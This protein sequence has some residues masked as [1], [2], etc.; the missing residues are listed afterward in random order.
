MKT[1][2]K[3][4]KF[5]LSVC[6]Q[7]GNLTSKEKLIEATIVEDEDGLI[8]F[9]PF[10]DPKEIYLAQHNSSIGETWKNHNEQFA[11]Y[12]LLY[13]K[14]KIVDVGG[15][16]GNIYKSYV[17]Y[18]SNVEWEIIDLNPTLENTSVKLT[19]GFYDP[20]YIQEGETVITSHFLEHLTDLKKFLIELRERAPKQHIF[21]LPN[22]KQ[23]ARNK[24]SATL[25]FEHPYYLT[26]DY[27]NYILNATGWKIVDKQY[28]RDHSIFF[29]TIPSTP[30]EAKIKFDY[31]ED[32]NNL[33]QYMLDRV[34]KI[35]NISKFYV[36]GAHYTY[37]YLLNMGI[38][39]D[40]VI[41]VVDNDT[42]KQGKRMYGTTTKVISPQDVVEEANVF[43]EMGPYNNEII[44]ELNNVKNKINYI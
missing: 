14:E 24:Y 25:M 11:K 15:G 27:L 29:S 44:K 41:A 16:S 31:K 38:S 40:Q 18:N 2:F 28:F 33:L 19:K 17:K 22:F 3:F 34:S 5:P 35:K 30:I 10:V 9:L 4:D 7:Q 32:I 1:L 39:V 36:F 42:S 12:V 6:T 13:E 8:T 37:Y 43:V 26:E 21:T 23:Y 20:K